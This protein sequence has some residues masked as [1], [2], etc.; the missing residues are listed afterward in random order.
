MCE[1]S[2]YCYVRRVLP[3]TARLCAQTLQPV[4]SSWLGVV[5]PTMFL[6]RNGSFLPVELRLQ[7]AAGCARIGGAVNHT[8]ILRLHHR[9]RPPLCNSAHH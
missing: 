8:P 6:R 9:L 1:T 7:R 4:P 5:L 2:A 3:M